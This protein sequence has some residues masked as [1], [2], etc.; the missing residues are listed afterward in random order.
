MRRYP[1]TGERADTFDAKLE[2]ADLLTA[3]CIPERIQNMDAEEKGREIA[4]AIETLVETI[5][6]NGT[7][8]ERL[9]G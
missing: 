2:L 3:H 4:D 9:Q 1:K 5:F 6:E 8:C 7:D